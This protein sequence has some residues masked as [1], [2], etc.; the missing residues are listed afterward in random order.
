[1]LRMKQGVNFVAM[2]PLPFYLMKLQKQTVKLLWSLESFQT[3]LS[4][5]RKWLLG[6]PASDELVWRA[7]G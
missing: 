1:M 5:I 4:V 7:E 6:A 2:H 3:P